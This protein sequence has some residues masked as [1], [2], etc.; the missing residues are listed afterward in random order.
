MLRQSTV[1]GLRVTSMAVTGKCEDCIM[2][3]AEVVP[4]TKP[5][6]RVA[7]DLW[8][9]ARVQTTNGKIFMLV[10]TD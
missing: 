8:G 4:K 2:V 6:E 9:P 10:T 5:Y 3:D 1:E 7:F